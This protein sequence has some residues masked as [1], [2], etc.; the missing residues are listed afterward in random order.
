ML[1]ASQILSEAHQQK[2]FFRALDHDGGNFLLS[3][4]L[5]PFEASL[6]THE[7]VS[8]VTLFSVDKRDGHRFLQSQ[9]RDVIH[10]LSEL[11]FSSLA[12]IQNDDLVNRNHLDA[13]V[14]VSNH[15]ATSIFLRIAI[16]VK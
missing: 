16:L 7:P 10:D 15:A 6:S 5:V 1:P 4:G 11:P 12:W 14:V 13:G 2:V 8:G 3:E 9:G